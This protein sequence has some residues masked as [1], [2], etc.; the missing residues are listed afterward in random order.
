ML[1]KR[2]KLK[3]KAVR[4]LRNDIIRVNKMRNLVFGDCALDCRC[5]WANSLIF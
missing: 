3:T 1:K 4:I 2:Q 5:L